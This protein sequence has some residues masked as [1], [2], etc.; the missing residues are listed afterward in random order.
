MRIGLDLGTSN[1]GAAFFDG[2]KVHLFPIDPAGRDPAVMRSVLYITRD[3]QVFAGQQAID[4][5][6]QQNI[7][8][9]SKLVRQV[10]G[11]VEMSF[12]ETGA[13]KGY[14]V[15]LQT[16]VREVHV[17][18]DELI[19]G[20]LLH[21]LKSELV[22]SQGR[23]TIFDRIYELEELLALY[24]R[25]V[26]ER[27]ERLS[28]EAVDSVVLGR[29]VHFAG[30]ESAE[31]DR[32]AEE[33]L[34]QA[35]GFAGFRQVEFEL[36]PVAAALHYELSIER[37]QN[38]VVFDLGGGTLDI[39]VMRVGG[40]EQRRVY[41]SGGVGIGGDLFDRRVIEELL[42]EHFGQ[43]TTWGDGEPFPRR[44]TEALLHWQTLVELSRPEALYFLRLARRSS[45]HPERVQALESLV[46][47]NYGMRLIEAVEQAKVA[48]S[49]QYMAA[50]ELHGDDLDLWQPLTRSQ[51]EALIAGAAQQIETCLRETLA[52]SGLAAEEIDVVVR[53]GGSSQ[54]PYL[55]QMV[56][57]M[58]DREKVVL[59][60]A[61]SGVTAGLAVRA[62]QT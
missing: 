29:P 8:R 37:P 18:V 1:S 58:F 43:G 33:R 12:A 22:S 47:N 40:P 20:R 42:L 15:S 60:S 13:V 32:R 55:V 7:G 45:S 5:Y 46:V 11:Q 41:A 25:E 34:R 21:S 28:G 27:V 50:I 59:S 39:T 35:A 10:V 26:R 49:T 52:R 56:E 17:L 61:F 19:P 57:R 6:H 23:T 30:S 3:Q 54:I 4:T 16:F 2:R 48:L 24:L 38:V 51:F 36:E 31:D 53:T 44:Y 9:P 14:P 62:A